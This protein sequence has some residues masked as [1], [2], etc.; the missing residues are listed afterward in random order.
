MKKI[1]IFIFLALANLSNASNY[2][3]EGYMNR[4][5]YNPGDIA[6][7]YVNANG[8][9]IGKKLY[10]STINNIIVDSVIVNLAPQSITNAD[11]WENG[12]GFSVSF[13]Y[14]IPNNLASGMYNWENKIFFIVKSSTK[15]A[16][17]T[18]IYPS[19]TEQAYNP[20][21]DKSLYSYPVTT[22]QHAVSFLRP[23]PPWSI[24]E[25]RG[26]SDGF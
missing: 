1:I 12:Y 19:N 20:A 6:H 14:V 22:R 15:S 25:V 21:G 24:S 23:L 4:S 7:V 2:I 18:L 9:Y 13:T 5:S 8:T 17:I 26:M 16:D 10:L 11:P 3:T